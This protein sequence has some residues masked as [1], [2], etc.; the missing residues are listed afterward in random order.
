[1]LENPTALVVDHENRQAASELWCQQQA[2]AVMQKGQVTREQESRRTT[3]RHPQR[4]AE[5]TIDAICPAVG[6]YSTGAA[7]GGPEEFRV[8]YTILPQ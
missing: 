1:M 3:V 7:T 2:I 8:P 6:K 4:G 5:R